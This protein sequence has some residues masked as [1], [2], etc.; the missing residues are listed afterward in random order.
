MDL[1]HDRLAWLALMD[2][3]QLAMTGKLCWI[4]DLW[5]AL[6]RLP[7][8]VDMHISPAMNTAN[9]EE[10]M[11]R[12]ESSIE[13]L[14]RYD[15]EHSVKTKDL[16]RDRKEP[17]R[18]GKLVSKVLAFRHY[19]CVKIP[20]H[21]IALTRVLLS[22]HPLASERMRWAER[23]RGPVPRQWRLCRFCEDYVEDPIHAMF[24]CSH[25]GL[26]ALCEVFLE[27]LF[28]D[29]PELKGKNV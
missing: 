13:T 1:P 29:I 8:P 26:M 5:I 28:K 16:F 6:A 24:V 4:N 7:C 15:L 20:K 22:S 23:Y 14:L 9:V 3:I 21:R 10:L 2:S 18:D 11:H 19:L 25:P 17:D 12:V 27:R